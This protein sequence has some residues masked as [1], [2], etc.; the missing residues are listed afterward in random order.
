[1]TR[2]TQLTYQAVITRIEGVLC[3]PSFWRRVL[4]PFAEHR[5]RAHLESNWDD[6]AVQAA[7]DAL[8]QSVASD[9][10]TGRMD[11]VPIP[12]AHAPAAAQRDA[13]A[14]Y[15]FTLTRY[16]DRPWGALHS[17]YGRIFRDGLSDGSLDVTTYGDCKAAFT[18]WRDASVRLFVCEQ[19]DAEVQQ[20]MLAHTKQGD[21]REFI[22]GW[23]PA[24][25]PREL[26]AQF[27]VEPRRTLF[28]TADVLEGQAANN[29]GFRS[30]LFERLGVFGTPRHD[31]RVE[32]NLMELF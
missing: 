11:F 23:S 8:R 27:G 29:A 15:A 31:L 14:E 6:P 32:T 9:M 3:A 13:V 16:P 4:L 5:L 28:L 7:I 24:L 1:M 20:L 22:S 17:L 25:E 12:P 19:V 18:R 21:L 26:A 2:S 10:A 30:V